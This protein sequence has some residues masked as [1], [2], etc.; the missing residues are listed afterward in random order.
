MGANPFT[1]MR[2]RP[3]RSLARRF[4]SPRRN[5]R[6]KRYRKLIKRIKTS[7][8]EGKPATEIIRKF[9]MPR[10]TVDSWLGKMN[11]DSKWSPLTTR[12]GQHRRI[13]TIAEE[14]SIA[15]RT[16]EEFLARHVIF[17]DEDSRQLILEEYSKKYGRIQNP[18]AHSHAALDMFEIS[19]NVTD[20]RRAEP[21]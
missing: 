5:Y 6:H 13:F 4:G 20:F 7:H 1:Q 17:S 9:N 11:A 16:R 12:L 2:N 3:Y 21:T 10:S 18:H 19:K 14:E 8:K 15:R